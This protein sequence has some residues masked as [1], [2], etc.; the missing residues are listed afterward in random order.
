MRR[1]ALFNKGVTLGVLGRSEEAIAVYDEL[2]ARDGDRDG[3]A[4]RE[5][6]ANAL[7]N[8]AFRLG[9]WDARRRRSPSPT[10]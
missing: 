8:K 2:I 9:C 4:L 10:S 1:L 3:L 7:H 5:P 6:V